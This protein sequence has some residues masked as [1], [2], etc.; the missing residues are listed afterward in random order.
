MIGNGL[1]T[2]NGYCASHTFLEVVR[3][4]F[5]ER[6]ADY[7]FIKPN[8]TDYLYEGLFLCFD[9]SSSIL[10]EA[11]QGLFCMVQKNKNDTT[12]LK[13]GIL[14][15]KDFVDYKTSDGNYIK[16]YKGESGIELMETPKIILFIPDDIDHSYWSRPFSELHLNKNTYYPKS[17]I[18]KTED[19]G[20]TEYFTCVLESPDSKVWV[21]LDEE[22]GPERE[23]FEYESEIY[24]IFY[25]Q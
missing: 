3:K 14:S 23:P 5:Y 22:G 21:V 11:I 7:C 24:G 15:D 6:N 4:Y 18:L 10:L 13:L 1:S 17:F 8:P 12:G 9:N 19:S 16:I 25:E 2:G 20:I